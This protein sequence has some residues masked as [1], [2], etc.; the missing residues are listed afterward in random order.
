M[1]QKKFLLLQLADYLSDKRFIKKKQVKV[2]QENM[3][4]RIYEIQFL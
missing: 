3:E 4:G 2:L 1:Y